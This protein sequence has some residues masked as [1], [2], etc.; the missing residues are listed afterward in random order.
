V[1]R[2]THPLKTCALNE[3]MGFQG[4]GVGVELLLLRVIHLSRM[5]VI[6]AH[7]TN[8]APLKGE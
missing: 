5:C 6:N 7:D 1:I 3:G 8:E 4:V 2:Y